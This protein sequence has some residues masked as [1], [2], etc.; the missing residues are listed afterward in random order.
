MFDG[1][2]MQKIR[3][4][5]H[6]SIKDLSK[7]TGIPEKRLKKY[8]QCRAKAIMENWNK[9]AK[10]LKCSI[11]AM[12]KDG[13]LLCLEPDIE[14]SYTKREEELLHEYY[15]WKKNHSTQSLK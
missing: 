15:Q 4:E 5:K 14:I 9:I 11:N 2:K 6:I 10:A 3:H 1:R 13:M 8:E 12:T 7:M